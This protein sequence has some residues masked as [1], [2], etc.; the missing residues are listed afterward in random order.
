MSRSP[1]HFGLGVVQAPLASKA[2]GALWV[3]LICSQKK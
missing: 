1:T 3:T 2:A